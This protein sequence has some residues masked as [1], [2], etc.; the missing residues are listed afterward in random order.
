VRGCPWATRLATTARSLRRPA[1][2]RGG[3][4]ARTRTAAKRE[5]HNGGALMASHRAIDRGRESQTSSRTASGLWEES[6]HRSLGGRPSPRY[7][8][9]RPNRNARN[10]RPGAFLDQHS[11][12]CAGASGTLP[13]GHTALV[14]RT[15]SG[16]ED[17]ELVGMAR[18]FCGQLGKQNNSQVAMT[19]AVA[20][21]AAS[22]PSRIC[23]I[24][25]ST[26]PATGSNDERRRAGGERLSDQTR[27]RFVL[28]IT[29]AVEQGAPRF[30]PVLKASL[31][32]AFT[33]AA[34]ACCASN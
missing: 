11:A 34:S 26:G 13:S 17:P 20:N 19:L 25:P 16:R 30:D 27:H 32:M 2:S 23:S 3:R 22:L 18:Q 15:P 5:H 9:G 7:G 1:N 21:E 33:R 8:S 29:A 10:V 12:S 4:H 6:R 31:L 14:L 28:Q 24:S